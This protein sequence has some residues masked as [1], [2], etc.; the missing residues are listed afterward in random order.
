VV[1]TLEELD[2]KALI[3]ILTEPKN[4]LT[5]AV[6]EACSTWKASSSRFREE[7]LQRHRPQGAETQDRRPGPAL[8]PRAG[9]C[10]TSCTSLPSLKDVTKV[11]VDENRRSPAIQAAAD[12][13]RAAQWPPRTVTF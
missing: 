4:A 6:P 11:V 8:H 9:A 3:K 13:R 7:A 5:Q 12:L 10:W 1:A 2:E